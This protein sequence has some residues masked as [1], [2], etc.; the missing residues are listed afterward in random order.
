MRKK[1]FILPLIF[2]FFLLGAEPSF[3]VPFKGVIVQ[4]RILIP[5]RGVLQT[6]GAE[7]EWRGPDKDIEVRAGEKVIA[8]RLNG[9]TASVGKREIVLDVPPRLFGD[10]TYVPLRFVSEALGA[11]I[12]WDS[13]AKTATVS[14]NGVTVSVKAPGNVEIKQ[15][16]YKKAN[17]VEIP[18]GAPVRARVVIGQDQVGKTENLDSL[19]RRYGAIAAIN[20]TYFNAYADRPGEPHGTPYGIIIKDGKVLQEGYR[21]AVVGLTADVRAKIAVCYGLV[22]EPDGSIR[23]L[24]DENGEKLDWSD[25]VAAVE[26]GPRLVKNGEIAVNFE[27]E[28]FHEAKITSAVGARS[29]IGVKQDGSILL[30][31]VPGATIHQLAELMKELGATDAMNL[32]GGASSGLWYSGRYLTKPGREISN[33]LAFLPAE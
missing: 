24:V 30:V 27:I 1:I 4:D 29:A 31:T 3:A 33:A 16:Q 32:D 12:G 18:F 5:L 10:V 11:D 20:G 28:N 9:A 23:Q 8:L 7:V 21:R 15:Y 26:A 22:T 6:L 17:V 19:A 14:L 2:F 13:G 25:V